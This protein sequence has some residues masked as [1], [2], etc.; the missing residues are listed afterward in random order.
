[1]RP[2]LDVAAELRAATCFWKEQDPCPER[3]FGSFSGAFP[4]LGI[5]ADIGF[6]IYAKRFADGI[7]SFAFRIS[8]L[9]FKHEPWV[10]NFPCC[11][12]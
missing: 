8:R 11:W 3:A 4:S 5:R 1:M 10:P 2:S 9:R 6:R 7:F 12:Q